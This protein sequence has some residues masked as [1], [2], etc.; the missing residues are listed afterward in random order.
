LGEG[1]VSKANTALVQ[2]KLERQQELLRR[3]VEFAALEPP[4]LTSEELAYG[5]QIL[6]DLWNEG[7]DR[8]E[9][10]GCKFP[11]EVLHKR[12]TWVAL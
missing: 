4:P 10:A 5:G 9:A 11:G 3:T 2:E 12:L 1:D 8:L 7:A 6:I